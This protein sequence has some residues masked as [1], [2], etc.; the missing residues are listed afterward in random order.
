M[1][2]PAGVSPKVPGRW[3]VRV[4]VSG[5]AAWSDAVAFDY[6]TSPGRQA[7]DRVAPGDAQAL[8]PQRL[9]PR[10]NPVAAA[11]GRR[12]LNPQPLP[13]REKAKAGSALQ[14]DSSGARS[15]LGSALQRR[16]AP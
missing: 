7:A 16:V 15:E 13:P 12:G 14:R 2:V 8:N 10:D 11:L 1:T 6:A 9:P 5:S 4:R 3:Q